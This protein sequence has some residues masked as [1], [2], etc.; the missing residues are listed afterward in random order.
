MEK[1]E[2]HIQVNRWKLFEWVIIEEPNLSMLSEDDI[3][4][5]DIYN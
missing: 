5:Y 2:A 3:G 1:F 4:S